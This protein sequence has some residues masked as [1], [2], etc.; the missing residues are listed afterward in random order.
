MNRPVED[1]PAQVTV[2]SRLNAG[3]DELWGSVASAEGVT[4]H[5]STFERRDV[6]R[7]IAERLPDGGDV[8]AIEDLADSFLLDARLVALDAGREPRWTTSEL[9]AIERQLV[10]RAHMLHDAG[11][12][13]AIPLAVDLALGERRRSQTSRRRWSVTSRRRAPASTR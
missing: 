3:T 1:I 8:T 5:A 11:A 7:A 6:I 9:L 4:Q 13:V 2:C 10:D 12:G